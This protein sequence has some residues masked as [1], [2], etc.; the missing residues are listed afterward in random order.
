MAREPIH[1]GEFL[2]DELE[3]IEITATELSRQID[4]PP[5]RISQIIHGKRDVTADTALRLGQFFGTGPE[6][7]LNLQKAYDLDKAKVE[8]G[9]KIDKINR[10]KPRDAHAVR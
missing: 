2:V 4:V 10:W 3:E 8:L 6:L 1:P 5:N 9:G 7:W